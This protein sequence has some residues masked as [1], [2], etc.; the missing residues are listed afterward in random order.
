[1]SITKQIKDAVLDLVMSRI[2]CK[3][4]GM[5]SNYRLN[6]RTNEVLHDNNIKVTG[7]LCT[8]DEVTQNGNLI[9][10]IK[11]RYASRKINGMYKMLIP[12]ITYI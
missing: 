10:K 3:N 12:L 8:T 7:K 4:Y 6:C 1:M 2:D 9:A 5:L 11:Y